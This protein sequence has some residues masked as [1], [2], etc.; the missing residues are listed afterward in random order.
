[1]FVIFNKYKSYLRYLTKN[2][3]YYI[4]WFVET[5]NSI[6]YTFDTDMEYFER[7]MWRLNQNSF[8]FIDNDLSG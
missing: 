6:Q 8:D 3:L 7:H 2:N 4:D 5:I 1:M